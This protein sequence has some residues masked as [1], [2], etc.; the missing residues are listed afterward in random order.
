MDYECK[1]NI[2]TNFVY[3]VMYDKMQTDNN[4]DNNKNKKYTEETCILGM[5]NENVASFINNLFNEV[6][7]FELKKVGLDTRALDFSVLDFKITLP[8]HVVRHIY[9]G[10]GENGASDF[11]M[12]NVS[13]C[14]KI[15][16]VL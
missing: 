5:L 3:R 10:H 13:D 1:S 6:E 2:V 7:I 9:S 15:L 12:S 14:E 4:N 16:D 8:A 11:S